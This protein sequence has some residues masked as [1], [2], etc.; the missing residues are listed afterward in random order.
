[1]GSP[2]RPTANLEKGPIAP[3]LNSLRVRPTMESQHNLYTYEDYLCPCQGIM[4]S[5]YTFY[6]GDKNSDNGIADEIMGHSTAQES[7]GKT[8]TPHYL[9]S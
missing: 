1:M 4:Q 7:L 2:Q 5:F 8:L 9:I 3:H 6:S